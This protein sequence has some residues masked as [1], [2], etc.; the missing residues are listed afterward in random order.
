MP[1]SLGLV[2]LEIGNKYYKSVYIH[3]PGNPVF[4]IWCMEQSL[5]KKKKSVQAKMIICSTIYKIRKLEITQFNHHKKVKQTM[6][7]QQ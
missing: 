1:I 3:G 7:Q 4:G 6:P 5:G 2:F